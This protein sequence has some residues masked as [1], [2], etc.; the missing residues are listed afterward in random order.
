MTRLITISLIGLLA[1]NPNYNIIYNNTQK[2]KN[3]ITYRKL[4]WVDFKPS[5]KRGN[6]AAL[7]NTGIVYETTIFKNNIDIEISCI[8][9]V[10]VSFVV[11]G[12]MN[13]RILSHEQ[14]HFDI[15]YIYSI[16]FRDRLR[17]ESSLDEKKISDIYNQI[18]KEWNECQDRYDLETNHSNSQENQD[19]WNNKLNIE[20]NKITK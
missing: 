5:G 15:T 4:Q 19:L 11:S 9:D 13:D 12:N 17:N 20:L 14:K 7:S 1:S 2:A 10:N 8:F 16:K 6:I 18:I 3:E